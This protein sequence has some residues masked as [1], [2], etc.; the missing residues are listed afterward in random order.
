MDENIIIKIQKRFRFCKFLISN[1]NNELDKIGHIY[2]SLM[3]RINNNY[4]NG[5]ITQ[6]KFNK[7]ITILEN[8]MEKYINI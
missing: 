5:I 2:D 4:T 1:F 7:Y 3:Y 6:Y 8:S